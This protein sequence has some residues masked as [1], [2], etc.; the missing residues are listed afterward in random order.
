MV[1]ASSPSSADVGALRAT[2]ITVAPA[3]PTAVAIPRPRPR[4]AP[5]TIVVLP[6]NSLMV[7][8][9]CSLAF[10]PPGSGRYQT[11]GLHRSLDRRSRRDSLLKGLEVCVVGKV[12]LDDRRP[13]RHDEE[14]CVSHA[15]LVAK[16]VRAPGEL[17]IEQ[18]VTLA[19][20]CRRRF[21]DLR[22]RGRAEKRAIAAV[23]F[24]RDVVERFLQPHTRERP[25]RRS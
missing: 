3:A 19:Q 4:L 12:E 15:E 16:Q 5:T 22:R 17:R 1:P 25:V 8:S 23:D 14:I 11:L 10:C 21:T 18:R 6:D 13:A 7:S 9:C 2:A 24:A 20:T